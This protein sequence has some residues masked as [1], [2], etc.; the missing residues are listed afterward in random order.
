M[1]SSCTEEVGVQS[2]TIKYEALFVVYSYFLILTDPS[3]EII[4]FL[5]TT[6]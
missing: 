5:H 6:S 4:V 1:N 2:L 3:H